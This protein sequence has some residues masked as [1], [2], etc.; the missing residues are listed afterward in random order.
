M[1]RFTVFPLEADRLGEAY[2]LIRAAARVTPEQW[3]TFA[4]EL[5]A[6]G[7]GVLAAGT[8]DGRVYGVATYR[9]CHDLRHEKSLVAEA[10]ASFEL[11]G[12]DRVRQ[13]LC[14]ALANLAATL[15]CH[16]LILTLAPSRDEAAVSRRRARWQELGLAL[17]TMNFVQVVGSP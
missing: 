8:G 15:G 6:A 12:G 9:I 3:R 4:L 14:A 1:P 13:T 17:D 11:S 5:R 2:P 10:F 16:S 7:G